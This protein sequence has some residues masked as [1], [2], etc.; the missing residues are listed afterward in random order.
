MAQAQ[1]GRTSDGTST[2][3]SRL[4][5]ERRTKLVDAAAVLVAERGYHG[6][7]L[8]DLGAAVGISGPAVYRHFPN[9]EAVLVE[10]LVGV[11]E[12]LHA[13]GRSVVERGLAPQDTLREL[14]HFHLEFAVGSPRL[15]DIQFREL[16]NLPAEAGR[17]VRSL[18]RRYV[19]IWVSTLRELD[20]SRSEGDARVQAHAAFG[21]LNSTPH[22]VGRVS[23]DRLRSSLSTMVLDALNSRSA[24]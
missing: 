3:R 6:L 23:S 1:I 10:L 11:S 4:K 17:A 8:E 15:I 22:S 24:P 18:Q 2:E 7:R 19:E 9:K 12:F 21:L 20:P 16:A 5:A 14:V 13:G